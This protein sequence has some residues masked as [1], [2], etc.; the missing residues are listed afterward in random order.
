M[1]NFNRE[2][3]AYRWSKLTPDEQAER[4]RKDA[5]ACIVS[6]H[7]R[8]RAEGMFHGNSD[9][10]M[11]WHLKAIDRFIDL[12]FVQVR[13]D[14]E[15]CEAAASLTWTVDGECRGQIPD[16]LLYMRA[17]G[18]RVRAALLKEGFVAGNAVGAL[19]VNATSKVILREYFREAGHALLMD[20]EEMATM[21]ALRTTGTTVRIYRG[22]GRPAEVTSARCRGMSWSR[23]RAT[24]ER[25]ANGNACGGSWAAVLT[26]DYPVKHILA[27]WETSGRE[28]E[29]VIDPT[30]A[31]NIFEELHAYV[32]PAARA[33]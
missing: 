13:D 18:P 21:A 19:Y 29:V 22:T 24:A 32:E 26:C 9:D 28:S 30:K 23:D 27:L 17:G 10:P 3:A 7:A 14:D 25:F 31:R 6:R 4:F 1:V 5:I 8:L 11:D 33:A 15:A 2:Y 12:V 20:E 16:F